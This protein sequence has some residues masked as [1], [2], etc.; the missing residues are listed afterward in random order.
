MTEER[1]GRSAQQ[2]GHSRADVGDAIF[3]VDLPQPAHAA[4]LI[5]LQKKARALALRAEIGVRLQLLER[6]AG[7]VEDAEDGNAKREQ[8]RKHVRKR[9]RVPSK[10][11]GAA[12]AGRERRH[13]PHRGARMNDQ[14]EPGDAETRSDR[15]CDDLRSGR[16]RREEVERYRQ[17]DRSASEH[18]PD[19]HPVWNLPSRSTDMGD[20]LGLRDLH[21]SEVYDGDGA[22]PGEQQH[23]AD[24]IPQGGDHHQRGDDVRGREKGC[25]LSPRDQLDIL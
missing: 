17:P 18:F 15:R 4:L 25:E 10:E 11:Q 12:K 20:R 24:L 1:A 22:Q 8:D 21:R 23:R 2:S 9:H 6:P 5:F 7:D 3:R 14:A 13:P 19:Q 16:D